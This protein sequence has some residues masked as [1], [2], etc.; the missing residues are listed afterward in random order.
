MLLNGAG[1]HRYCDI[2]FWIFWIL[3]ITIFAPLQ[4]SDVTFLIQQTVLTLS[5][6]RLVIQSAL[7][8]IINQRNL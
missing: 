3:Q 8:M 4:L 2:R 1:Q 7:L 6:P 5:L